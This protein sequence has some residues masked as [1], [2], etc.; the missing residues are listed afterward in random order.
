MEKEIKA[1]VEAPGFGDPAARDTVMLYMSQHQCG[2][3]YPY[4]TTMRGLQMH[5]G[6]GNISPHF[7]LSQ[8]DKG[9][10]C[11]CA[12]WAPSYC[13]HADGTSAE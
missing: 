6:I 10:L 7:L 11:W 4:A 2:P 9:Q 12:Q 13:L 8:Q 5:C 1:H 3:N